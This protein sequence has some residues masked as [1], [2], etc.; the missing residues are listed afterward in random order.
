MQAQPLLALLFSASQIPIAIDRIIDNKSLLLLATEEQC[1]LETL[2]ARGADPNQKWENQT[3]TPLIQAILTN[4]I[5]AV[6]LLLA[7]GALPNLSIKHHPDLVLGC[8]CEKLI[9]LHIALAVED[10]QP[11]IVKLLL[12]AG[13]SLSEK[14]SYWIDGKKYSLTPSN[15]P[16]SDAC[17]SVFHQYQLRQ[18]QK[19]IIR[20]VFRFFK[21]SCLT[22]AD[23]PDQYTISMQEQSLS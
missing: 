9:P 16:T 21:P 4:N 12:Q 23:A 7:F 5:E 15:I 13:A 14:T 18:N 22:R 19:S 20:K 10:P 11:D 17:R 1:G 3:N 6:S 8:S 2:L